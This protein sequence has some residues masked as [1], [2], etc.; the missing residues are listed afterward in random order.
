MVNIKFSNNNRRKINYNKQEWDNTKK[1]YHNYLK[2]D[3]WKKIRE[4]VLKR[5]GYLC[6]DCRA[7]GINKS[8]DCVHH[9]DYDFLYTFR[10][11]EFCISLCNSCHE[12]RTEVQDSINYEDIIP[13]GGFCTYCT[14]PAMT[15]LDKKA[16]CWHH[17]GMIFNNNLKI[18]PYECEENEKENYSQKIL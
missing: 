14:F 3:K 10:E 8:A 2:S 18:Y 6:C 17:Q 16:L 1:K 7:E 9:M 5:D 11:K 12:A 4:E 13:E 15:V